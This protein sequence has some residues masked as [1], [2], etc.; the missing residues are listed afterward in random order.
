MYLLEAYNMKLI[1]YL[2]TWWG[3]WIF[4]ILLY[5]LLSLSLGYFDGIDVSIS[6][7]HTMVFGVLWL[8]VTYNMRNYMAE[9]GGGVLGKWHLFLLDPK[10]RKELSKGSVSDEL[11]DHFEKNGHP[12][13]WDAEMIHGDEMLWIIKDGGDTYLIKD[14]D[15]VLSVEWKDA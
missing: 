8:L 1:V 14:D 6:L 13:S 7:R 11:R 3:L 5:F 2:K 12:L 10:L 4:T 15:N 9:K